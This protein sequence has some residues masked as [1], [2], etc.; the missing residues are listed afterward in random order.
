MLIKN[1]TSTNISTSDLGMRYSTFG[2]RRIPIM[3]CTPC[4]IGTNQFMIFTFSMQAFNE[5]LDFCNRSK[6][7]ERQTI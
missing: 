5:S 6:P 1:A 3:H 4:W 2:P 7:H